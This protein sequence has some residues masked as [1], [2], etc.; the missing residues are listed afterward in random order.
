MIRPFRS[1]ASAH[2]GEMLAI[3]RIRSRHVAQWCEQ[4]GIREGDAVECRANTSACL[5][6]RTSQGRVIS[7][8][9]DWARYI[10]IE[11]QESISA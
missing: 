11:A 10:Q 1:L 5:I 8:N 7:V 3:R 2:A 9:Q 6:V 4:L